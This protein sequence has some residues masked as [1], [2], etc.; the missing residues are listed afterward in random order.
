MSDELLKV[1]AESLIV[2]S[3]GHDMDLRD[4]ILEEDAKSRDLHVKQPYPQTKAGYILRNAVQGEHCSNPGP[5]NYEWMDKPHRIVYT[6]ASEIDRLNAQLNL[7]LS[8]I[9]S[10]L[11][12]KADECSG[13]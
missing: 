1:T 10:F 11:N 5:A 3:Y 7:A 9:N 6:A 13:S 2:T 4:F 12:V 8:V